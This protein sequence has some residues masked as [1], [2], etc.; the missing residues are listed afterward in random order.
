MYRCMQNLPST[1]D[2][3]SRH[4][5]EQTFTENIFFLQVAVDSVY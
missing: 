3:I 1:G 4:F 5:Y 2:K